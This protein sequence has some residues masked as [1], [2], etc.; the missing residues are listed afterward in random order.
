MGMFSFGSSK[1]K[2]SY[3]QGGSAHYQQKGF[4]SG[5]GFGSFSSSARR[6]QAYPQQGYGQP[7]VQPV[8][9]AAPQTAAPAAGPTCAQCGAALP[10]GAKFCL[11]CGAK[12]EPAGGSFCAQCGT[13]LPAGA[14]FCSSCGT[15]RV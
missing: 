3:G 9:Q 4:L 14:K 11:N 15:P 12:A 8:P 2:R 13:Q 7:S 10:A 6:R 5:F 1:K